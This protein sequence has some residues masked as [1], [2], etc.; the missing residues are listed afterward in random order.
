MALGSATLRR[1][2]SSFSRLSIRNRLPVDSL[3][4]SHG[5]GLWLW[6]HTNVRGSRAPEVD[7]H[8]RCRDDTAFC[9]HPP[10][11]CLWR[12]SPMVDAEEFYF[13]RFFV[14]SLPEISAIASLQIGRAS[15]RE[16]VEVWVVVE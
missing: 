9:H 12:S 8:S 1:D 10:Q 14:R 2:F 3:D 4:R 7:P 6:H 15:C 16:R 5:R 13:H 11:Q